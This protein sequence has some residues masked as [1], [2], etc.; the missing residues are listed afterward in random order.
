MGCYVLENVPAAWGSMHNG[1]KCSANIKI[2]LQDSGD[3][4]KQGR[5][6]LKYFAWRG[7][8]TIFCDF[9]LLVCGCWLMFIR[10][11][12]WLGSGML[13]IGVI[14]GALSLFVHNLAVSM[15]RGI[16]KTKKEVERLKNGE[17]S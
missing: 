7:R 4:K 10:G 2:S 8:A 17:G 1:L 9:L 14:F 11:E 6:Y 3:V 16:E 15:D 5:P 12:L 13:I